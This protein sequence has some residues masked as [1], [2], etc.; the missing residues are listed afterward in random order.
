MYSSYKQDKDKHVCINKKYQDE[1]QS[2]LFSYVNR[3]DRVSNTVLYLNSR[4]TTKSLRIR[5]LRYHSEYLI[6]KSLFMSTPLDVI[7]CR[8]F[9]SV[10]SHDT[11]EKFLLNLSL[12]RLGPLHLLTLF[13]THPSPT[14]LCLVLTPKRDCIRFYKLTIMEL[15]QQFSDKFHRPSLLFRCFTFVKNI[16]FICVSVFPNISKP[17]SF[18][19]PV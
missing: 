2:L 1:G 11:F 14:S 15:P 12:S 5:T 18:L 7:F 6:L 19:S 16:R 9:Y 8:D 3:V 13:S 10:L 4:H 17:L